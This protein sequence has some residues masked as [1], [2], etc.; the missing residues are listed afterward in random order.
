MNDDNERDDDLSFG[1]TFLLIVFALAVLAV[2]SVIFGWG[3]GIGLV[4]AGVL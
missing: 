4:L 3:V 2:A 1:A